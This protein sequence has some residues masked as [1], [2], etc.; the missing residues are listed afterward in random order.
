ML[1]TLGLNNSVARSRVL[2]GG[3][4]ASAK[5]IEAE[6]EASWGWDIR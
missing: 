6:Q 1:D 3:V 5:L 4:A 2:V